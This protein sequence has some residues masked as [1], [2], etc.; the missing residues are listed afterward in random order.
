MNSLIT[1]C[2]FILIL[3]LYIHIANQFKKNE[4]LEIYETDFSN[5]SHFEDV[6]E[7]KQP[8][9][10][11]MKNILPNLY[12]NLIPEN[13]AQFSN[14]DINIKDTNDY[15][16]IDNE[17]IDPV[18]LPLHTS[19]KF[20]ESDISSH[21]FS[22]NNQE[23]LE[24]SG[25]NKKIE[26][27]DN[28]LKPPFTIH[29]SY[30]LLLGSCNTITPFKY[31]TDNRQFLCVTHGKIKI[32]MTSWKSSKYLH[33]HKDYIN[34]EFRSLIN[35]KHPQSEFITDY[36]KINFIEFYIDTGHML[37]IPPYWWYS[38]SYLD[39]PTTF[40]CNI[41]YNTMINCI[42]NIWDLSMYYLQQ[43]NITKK[44]K[45]IPSD[46]V[47]KTDEIEEEPQV[48][49]EEIIDEVSD[50]IESPTIEIQSNELNENTTNENEEN[51]Q[52]I[53][54]PKS[55]PI[56]ENIEYTISDI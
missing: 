18:Y 35:P 40:I 30:D 27:V 55:I 50:T 10:F 4:E 46:P 15:F 51:N 13:I 20:M 8:V 41:K 31:H 5:K 49:D 54:K 32:K 25:L 3:F 36:E 7:L 34:Y 17:S 37:Y 33:P 56:K 24:E 38:I 23:F 16:A 26:S 28:I 29:K 9:L 45:R 47:Y 14:H 1:L 44:I 52:E 21:L 39:D 11:N 48:K 43:Q 42:S 12:D 2:I 53:K 22:E 6:C 19:I